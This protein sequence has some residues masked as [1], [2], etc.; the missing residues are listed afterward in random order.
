MTLLWAGGA[1]LAVWLLGIAASASDA[2]DG[3]SA[4]LF[5]L[6]IA[7]A[8]VA[9][10]AFSAEWVMLMGH[11]HQRSARTGRCSVG[12]RVRSWRPP[13]PVWRARSQKPWQ[14]QRR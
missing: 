2:G 8:A 4:V 6:G 5:W 12:D 7:E 9:A 1:I 10:V 14:C 11:R 3:G 13:T